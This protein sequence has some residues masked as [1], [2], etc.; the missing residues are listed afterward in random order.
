MA[1]L[2][3]A[4]VGAALSL[5]YGS[6]ITSSINGLAVLPFII[7]VVDGSGKNV[8][9]TVE[10][11]GATDAAAVAEGAAYSSS[12][13]DAETPLAASL[14]WASYTKTASVTG[15]AAA[16][17]GA[18]FNPG[19]AGA[20]GGDLLR[21]QVLNQGRRVLLG[22]AGDMYAGDPTA[23]PVEIAGAAIAIDSSGTF[24]GINPG[25]YTDWASA[26]NTL[27]LA[28]ISVQN[29]RELLLTPVYDA[30]GEQPEFMTTTAT[31]FDKVRGL[32]GDRVQ[33]VQ[34]IVVARGGGLD[35]QGP[36]VVKLQHG[37]QGIMIDGVP[38]I[39]DPHCTSNVI[40]AWNTRYV[41][42]EQ[43]PVAAGL[44]ENTPAGILDFFRRI[45]DNPKLQMP[46]EM[47]EG[48]AARSAGPRPAVEVLGKDGD[49]SSVL[50]KAYVQ[51]RYTRRNAFGKLVLS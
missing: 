13:A 37:V 49:R 21:D 4:I 17:A 40:Y 41:Q 42:L 10:V 50:V 6:G 5:V 23:T 26:E 18:N 31:V 14:S 45:S 38:L 35:G 15:L 1:A 25:T 24:A 29:I 46:T 36:R 8:A 3:S 27:A 16:S 34:E 12:S 2:T 30:C 20:F 7:P 47:L 9:W 19:S 33:A 11:S 28:A 39:R 44:F 32:F 22:M 51:M 48:M 43:L